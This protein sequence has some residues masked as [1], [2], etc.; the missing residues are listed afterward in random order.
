MLNSTH[1]LTG[2]QQGDIDWGKVE[3]VGLGSA[4]RSNLLPFYTL[5]LTEKAPFP[6][7]ILLI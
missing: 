1:N 6:N 2:L 3:R 4:P 5:V 7:H